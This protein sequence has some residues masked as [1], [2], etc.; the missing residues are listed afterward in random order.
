MIIRPQEAC[1]RLQTQWQRHVGL[2]FLSFL[3]YQHMIF[4][5]A[6]IARYFDKVVNNLRLEPMV[7]PV[8][9]ALCD[10]DKMS[11]RFKG[12]PPNLVRANRNHIPSLWF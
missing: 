4:L 11:P 7:Y 8:T 10:V 6:L 2:Y 5:N 1:F 3:Q 12:M 9:N